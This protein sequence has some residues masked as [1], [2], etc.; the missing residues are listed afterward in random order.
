MKVCDTDAFLEMPQSSQLLYFH[1][2]LRAD[3]DGFI[4]NPKRI[5]RMIGSTDDDLKIL[6]AKRFML[7]FESGVCVVKHWL[8]HN[9]IRQDR[10]TPTQYV[11]EMQML[12][13]DDSTKKYSLIKGQNNMATIRQPTGNQLEPQIRLGKVRKDKNTIAA[14]DAA[15]TGEGK[16]INEALEG[17]KGVNPS[18]SRLYANKTQRAAMGRLLKQHGL[19]KMRQVIEFLPTSNMAKFAPTITTPLQL[20]NDL[21]KLFA[22]AQKQRDTGKGK[23]LII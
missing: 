1:L 18:Y 21:G 19:E 9:T 15:D 7:A 10:Y 17:F 5:M 6:L 14:Q 2:A 3:D 11:K 12:V 16:L 23:Q 20:E 4:A 13:I 22:W 8:I